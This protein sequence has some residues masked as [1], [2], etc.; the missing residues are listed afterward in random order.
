MSSDTNY[1]TNT[2]NLNKTNLCDLKEKINNIR[3]KIAEL[4]KQNKNNIE[5]EMYFL[6]NDSEFYEKFPFLIKKLIK[7]DS[8]ELLEK[9]L[10]S[11]E[12]I[13]KGDSTRA[14]VE[15]KLGQELADKYLHPVINKKD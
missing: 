8:N 2:D 12:K 14:T 4:L 13:D 3:I 15:A 5:I 7:N 9:M 10:D 1:D 6:E 11:I